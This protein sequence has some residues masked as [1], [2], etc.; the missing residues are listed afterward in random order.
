MK[1][2]ILSAHPDDLEMSCGGSAARWIEEGHEVYSLTLAQDVPQ[3]GYASTAANY[4]GV[5]PIPHPVTRDVVVSSKLIAQIESQI[6]SFSFNRI[7]THWKEDW[8]QDHR[9]CYEVGNILARKQPLELWY[10]SSHPYHLK[11]KEFSPDVFVDISNT[12]TVKYEAM[13]IYQDAIGKNWY[14]G[15]ISHDSWRGSFINSRAAEVFKIGHMSL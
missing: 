13:K 10:M 15:V 7:I 2:L 12:R 6:E 4:L 5:I 8:H 9:A 11:Y 3:T 1:I 14:S